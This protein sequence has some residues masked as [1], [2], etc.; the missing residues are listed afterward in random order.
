MTVV[1]TAF[2]RSPDGGKGLARDMRVRWA[3]EEVG[4]RSR[5]D[6]TIRE[7]VDFDGA[8]YVEHD[9]EAEVLPGIRLL[10]APSH[11]D[12]H[13]IVVVES[14]AGTTVIAG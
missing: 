5:D 10:P 12:G 4:Q 6:Y 9:G 13:Q 7:W 1:I 3:L 14:D 2:E 8:T 11:S